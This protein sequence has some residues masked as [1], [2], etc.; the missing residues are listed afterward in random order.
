MIPYTIPCKRKKRWTIAAAAFGLILA[1]LSILPY[2]PTAVAKPSL[3]KPQGPDP[4]KA[5]SAGWQLTEARVICRG[6]TVSLKDGTLS[7]GYVVE[8]T[9]TPI[10]NCTLPAGRGRF[11]MTITSFLPSQSATSPRAGYWQVRGRWSITSY[12]A[13]KI[14]K[15]K[16]CSPAIARG[17]LFAELPFNPAT[18]QGTITALL[19]LVMTPDGGRRSAQVKGR[20]CGNERFEGTIFLEPH[21]N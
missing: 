17:V 16:N 11:Q 14:G 8:A 4:V 19:N 13:A 3:E 7:G 18:A 21:G 9:A 5:A 6:Q 1:L 20:F 12:M 10:G 15:L 2:L